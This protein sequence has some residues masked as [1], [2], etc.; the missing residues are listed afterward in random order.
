[1]L[2][3]GESGDELTV[4]LPAGQYDVEWF[5]LAD[6]EWTDGERVT[7]ATAAVTAFTPP[8][9]SG[10]SVLHLTRTVAGPGDRSG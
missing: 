8:V 5:S 4:Q 7:V 2:E 9:G 3:H 6:R 10:A 1:M